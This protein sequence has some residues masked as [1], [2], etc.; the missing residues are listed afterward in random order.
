MN[1]KTLLICSAAAALL[2]GCPS[3]T[4]PDDPEVTNVYILSG[5]DIPEPTS[6]GFAVGFNLDGMVSDGTGAD[7]VGMAPD[8]TSSISGADGV[9]NQLAGVVG[10]L[11][12]ELPDGVAGALREQIALG[13][14]L[15]VMEVTSNGIRNDSSASVHLYLGQAMNGMC[16]NAAMMCPANSL[17]PEDAAVGMEMPCGPTTDA[18]GIIEADQEFTMT[19]D[20]ATVPATITN[21][22]LLIELPSLPLTL[23]ISGNM[24]ELNLLNANVGADISDA[25]LTNGEIGAEVTVQN[26]LDVAAVAGFDITEELIRTV[27][28][29]DLMPSADGTTCNSISAGLSFEAVAAAE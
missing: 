14:F 18:G 17:C 29:P 7:C 23:V 11:A 12:G 24:L 26:I 5:G 3:N 19:M 9:D 27:A 4:T 6:D 15:L 21:G 20:I 8:F 10:L 22:H 28:G 25:T 16:D 1:W 13:T 2:A